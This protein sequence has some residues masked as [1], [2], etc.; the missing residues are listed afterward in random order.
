MAF[1]AMDALEAIGVVAGKTKL[2]SG[3]NTSREA[4][5]AVISGRLAALAGGHVAL[6]IKRL[7]A[8]GSDASAVP[9]GRLFVEFNRA[10]LTRNI[11]IET[12]KIIALIMIF[13]ALLCAMMI[14][15]LRS[16][17]TAPLTKLRAH[18]SSLAPEILGRPMPPLRSASKWRDEMDMVADGFQTLHSGI[19][20]YVG[21]RK[22]A[23][24]QLQKERDQ[25][26]AT[27]RDR[28][29]ARSKLKQFLAVVSNVSLRFLNAEHAG[30]PAAVQKPCWNWLISPLQKKCVSRSAVARRMTRCGFGTNSMRTKCARSVRDLSCLSAEL[31]WKYCASTAQT[32]HPTGLVCCK[33]NRPNV[34]CFAAAIAKH[35]V[36]CWHC[37]TSRT[38]RWVTAK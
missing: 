37:L 3:V 20:R 1:G 27:V 16:K 10:L 13:T 11:L 31:N 35:T 25:L 36:I 22:L 8:G 23:N 28:T 38:K 21:E 26:D 33:H 19:E 4:M 15:V 30:F 17:V 24:E 29:A 14:R 18:V 7:T 32:S 5:D 6:D 2:F 12:G 34:R 9:L